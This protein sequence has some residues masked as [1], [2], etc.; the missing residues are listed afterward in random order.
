MLAVVVDVV[1]GRVGAECDWGRAGCRVVTGIVGVVRGREGLGSSFGSSQD[2][3]DMK[4]E[5]S[6]DSGMDT[7]TC[8]K[9]FSRV[10]RICKE[11]TG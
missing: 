4:G 1:V 11:I 5:G 8:K 2:I 10:A 7:R 9:N 3:A 6:Q